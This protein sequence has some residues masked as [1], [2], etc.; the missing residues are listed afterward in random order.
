[1]RVQDGR[2]RR[3]AQCRTGWASQDWPTAG[4]LK[5]TGR[6]GCCPP[7]RHPSPKPG[8]AGAACP[9]FASASQSKTSL[10]RGAADASV[11]EPGRHAAASCGH[12]RY[13]P[14]CAKRPGGLPP[15]PPSVGTSTDPGRRHRLQLRVGMA[16]FRGDSVVAECEKVAM[17]R[18]VPSPCW[19]APVTQR[20]ERRT[21]RVRPPPICFSAGPQVS[22]SSRGEQFSHCRCSRGA[23]WVVSLFFSLCL[24]RLVPSIGTGA[25]Q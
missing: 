13:P 9:T 4:V 12:G 22:G 20:C 11:L 16:T 6:G 25:A 24:F 1:M 18:G 15:P 19:S 14:S 17:A 10:A 5:T 7:A 8:S 3:R 23:N 2:G 21:R